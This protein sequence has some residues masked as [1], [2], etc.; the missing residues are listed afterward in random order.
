MEYISVSLDM[1]V[2]TK[3]FGLRYR[4]LYQHI[5][6]FWFPINKLVDIIG[7]KLRCIIL[8]YSFQRFKSTR[9]HKGGE[10]CIVTLVRL[11]S[12]HY[13]HMQVASLKGNC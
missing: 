5:D 12:L 10:K 11:Q 9:E 1:L 8:S 3:L 7:N 4:I 2:L 13:L 6:P